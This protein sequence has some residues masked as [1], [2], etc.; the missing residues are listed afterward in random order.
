MY[1]LIVEEVFVSHK[2]LQEIMSPFGE[3]D[4]AT[5]GPQAIKGFK[6]AGEPSRP[7]DLSCCHSSLGN[8]E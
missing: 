5:N 7:Y 8:I 1:P 4:I 2:I 3:G 6:L